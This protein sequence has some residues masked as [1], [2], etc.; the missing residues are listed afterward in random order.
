MVI[1]SAF[2]LADRASHRLDAVHHAVETHEKQL[3][4][5]ANQQ[6][7]QYRKLFQRKEDSSIFDLLDPNR[8]KKERPIG[9]SGDYSTYG[10]ASIV[11]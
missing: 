6:L 7:Q 1:F 8:L 3:R 9:D 10:P 11:T 5:T 4:M 2:F